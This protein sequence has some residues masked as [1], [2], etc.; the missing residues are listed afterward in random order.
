MF[1]D[2]F[3]VALGT[4]ASRVT[5][6]VRVVILGVI[7][8]Q[9]ALADAFDGA[10]NSP[11]SV[12][13]L[14][15]GGVLAATLVPLFTRA[16][17]EGD[18]D[19]ESSVVTTSIIV[20][21]ATT[22][23]AMVSAP[24]IFRLY[25]L[26]PSAL[27]DAAQYRDAGTQMARVFLAQIFFYGLT[28]LG[29]ALLNARR[30]FAMAAW[31]PALSNVVT[32]SFLLLIPSTIDGLPTLGDV[33]MNGGFFWLLTLSSTVGV[34]SMAIVLW[35]ALHRAGFRPS[36]RPDFAHPAVRSM[37]RLSTWT[38]GY[39]VTNQVALVVIKNLAEPGSGNQDAY[40]KAFIFFMLPHSLLALS[41]ATTVVPELVHRVA[42]GD[43]PGFARRFTTGLRWIVVLVAP[44]SV[45][46]AVLAHPLIVTVLQHGN[47]GADAALNTSRALTGFAIGLVGFSTYLYSLRA[48]YA[49]Q[50]TRTPF[51]VNAFQNTVNI[52]LAALLFDAHG[53]LGL[54]LAFGISYLAAAGVTVCLLHRRHRA[55]DW[56]GLSPAV[57]PIA[58]GAVVMTLVVWQ[59]HL[60]LVPQG[61][62]GH[63]VEVMVATVLG[64]G[65]YVAVLWLMGTVDPGQVVRAV[66]RR[67]TAGP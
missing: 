24:L 45:L 15:V 47:F 31:A 42:D 30:L 13:E 41:I 55:V 10:N 67:V 65:G 17:K 33:S 21:A 11:N 50:D 14:L 52:A 56:T 3:V 4:A 62:T 61:T 16:F 35:P 38:L 1:K 28:A 26:Q 34:A 8:G 27:V 2:T 23:L 6:L 43:G 58:T 9:T 12:Y 46:M 40:S 44:A 51:L 5:G 32:I 37:L 59:V 57:V 22:V 64:G 39:V 60:R 53:V 48:F 20:L 66:R 25:S 7:L 36:F 49:H 54:G 18:A 19:A 63:L 29:T